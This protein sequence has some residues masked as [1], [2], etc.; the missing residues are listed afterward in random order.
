MSLQNIIVKQNACALDET[1]K[2]SLQRHLEK[3]SKAAH[4]SIAKN[5]LQQQQIR[6]LMTINNKA[7]AR[8]STKLIVL[9][10]AKVMGYEE[11]KEAR[12]KRAKKE[13]AK[14]AKGKEKR[15]RKRKSST[16]DT[17]ALEPKVKE[18]RAS[19][20]PELTTSLTT[21]VVGMRVE[22]GD[23]TSKSWTVPVAQMW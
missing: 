17:D 4:L 15:G 20:V 2:H 8:R 23:T 14:E 11:L 12:E 13:A 18:V 5:A 19:K 6:F 7:K 10:T 21:Q 16:L 3:F 9:G 1:S 22:E